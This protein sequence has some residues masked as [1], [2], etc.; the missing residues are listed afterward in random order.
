MIINDL[1]K[2]PYTVGDM[3]DILVYMNNLG[4]TN[5]VSNYIIILKDTG[6]TMDLVVKHRKINKMIYR[7]IMDKEAYKQ[8]LTILF[9]TNAVLEDIPKNFSEKQDFNNNFYYAKTS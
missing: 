2:N 1:I 3:K 4:T 7:V 8:W 9:G 5:K 6:V